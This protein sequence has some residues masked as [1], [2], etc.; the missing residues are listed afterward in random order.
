MTFLSGARGRLMIGDGVIG[1]GLQRGAE[2]GSQPICPGELPRLLGDEVLADL[3]L[4]VGDRALLAVTGDREIRE[5]ADSVGFVVA[6]HQI[7][8]CS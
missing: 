7:S 4:D 3:E 6:H 8:S 1:D 2:N 5:R